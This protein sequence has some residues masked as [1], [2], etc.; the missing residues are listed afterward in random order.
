MAQNR[1]IPDS[2]NSENVL[3]IKLIDLLPENSKKRFL[4][5]LLNLASEANSSEKSRDLVTIVKEA[6]KNTGLEKTQYVSSASL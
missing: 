1:S 6:E 2:S 4:E 3:T 5:A